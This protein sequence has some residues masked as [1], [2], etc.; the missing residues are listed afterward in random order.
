MPVSH[1]SALRTVIVQPFGTRMHRYV[2][3]IPAYPSPR[4]YRV[5][6]PMPVNRI[7]PSPSARMLSGGVSDGLGWD[8]SSILSSVA[9]GA[10]RAGTW[11]VNTLLTPQNVSSLVSGIV[12]KQLAPKKAQPTT[13]QVAAPPT[14]GNVPVVGTVPVTG[15]GGG[16]YI[17]APVYYGGGGPAMAPA[18]PSAP[19]EI[20]AVPKE[21]IYLG[22]GGLALVLI[23][24]RR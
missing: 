1:L 6:R 4:R 10:V 14:V 22:L 23:L 5:A 17:P 2:S 9:S 7:A 3:R 19:G 16:G 15:G 21:Y 11:A 12:A 13:I 18:V 8:F 20:F 24:S